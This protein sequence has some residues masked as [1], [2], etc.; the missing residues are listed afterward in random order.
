MTRLERP[1]T[2]QM[3]Y[4]HSGLLWAKDFVWSTHFNLDYFKYW[5]TEANYRSG[6]EHRAIYGWQVAP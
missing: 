5:I 2:E 1:P 3:G 4:I 6:Y